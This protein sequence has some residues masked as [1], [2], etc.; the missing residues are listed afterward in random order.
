M[1]LHLKTFIED[2]RLEHGTRDVSVQHAPKLGALMRHLRGI[3]QVAVTTRG[4]TRSA[5]K[6]GHHPAT[7]ARGRRQAK[8]RAAC[9]QCHR[10]RCENTFA[11]AG[12]RENEP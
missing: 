9:E 8:M 4:A 12:F 11:V 10:C 6:A 7:T 3:S 2:T 1:K 5:R